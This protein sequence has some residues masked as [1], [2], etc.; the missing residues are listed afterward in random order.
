[1]PSDAGPRAQRRPRLRARLALFAIGCIVAL[2]LAEI[3]VR[4]WRAATDAKAVGLSQQRTEPARPRP[5]EPYRLGHL[6]RAAQHHDIVFELLPDLDVPFLGKRLVTNH[7]GFRGPPRTP[8]KP[9]N[10]FRIVGLGDSVLFGWGVEYEE[11]GL[12]K[13][14]ALVQQALPGK[15]VEAI[16][17]G[18]PGYNT[19]MEAVVLQEKGLRFQP[20]LVIVDFVGNDLDLPNYL[21]S[22]PNYWQLDKSFLLDLVWRMRSWKGSELNGPFVWAPTREHGAFAQDPAAVPPEYRH[23]VGIDAFRRGMRSIVDAGRAHGFKV[24]VTCHN[25]MWQQIRD[26][27]N[28]V[29]VPFVD[30]GYRVN[31]WLKE[32]GHETLLGSPLTIDPKDPHPSP[33]VHTWWAEAAFA[34]LCELGWLPR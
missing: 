3:S 4:G 30:I 10:G 17:T 7:D 14:E 16:D 33:M 1:M 11:A 9:A 18:V 5:G 13:L 29:Q 34:K 8:A 25:E 22:P 6:I 20:D 26:V 12:P 23:L 32:H 27:C 24:L 15:L 19:A 2:L 31:T 21:W 28:E